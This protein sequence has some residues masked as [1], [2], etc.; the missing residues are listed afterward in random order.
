VPVIPNTGAPLRPAASRTAASR[1]GESSP[2]S[3]PVIARATADRSPLSTC[4]A[5]TRRIA[6]GS[7]SHARTT[8]LTIPGSP[9]RCPSSGEKI[10]T[11]ASRRRSISSCTITPPPPPTTCT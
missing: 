10:V 5:L 9:I 4:S 3:A 6:H 11:P 1:S 7:K 2:R 8:E